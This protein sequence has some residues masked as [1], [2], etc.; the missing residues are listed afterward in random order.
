MKPKTPGDDRSQ[1]PCQIVAKYAVAS[2]ADSP[3]AK[4]SRWDIPTI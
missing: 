3:L 2:E 4:D 1:S